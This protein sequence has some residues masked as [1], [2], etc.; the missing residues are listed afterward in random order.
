V[1]KYFARGFDDYFRLMV[2]C[3]FSFLGIKLYLTGDI[4]YYVSDRLIPF[5]LISCIILAYIAIV[6]FIKTKAPKNGTNKISYALFII[7]LLMGYLITPKV[8]SQAEV[9]IGMTQNQEIKNEYNSSDRTSENEE[10]LNSEDSNDSLKGEDL[11]NGIELQEEKNSFKSKPKKI[12]L[13]ERN[14][15]IQLDSLYLR[16][17]EYEGVE[18][19]I[20]GKIYK[21]EFLEINQFAVVRPVMSCCAADAAL[22][23][24]VCINENSI[25][26]KEDDWVKAE[27]KV[28]IIDGERGNMPAIKVESVV[29][30]EKPDNEFVYPY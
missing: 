19:E 22:I 30:V 9:Q 23:G 3:G 14:Y 7:P 25:D 21:D 18:I 10:I 5:V 1:N 26:I 29:G 2:L 24:M 8:I 11:N 16:M 28:I 20:T 12:V 17:E 6:V 27:G 4:N 15:L 13:E